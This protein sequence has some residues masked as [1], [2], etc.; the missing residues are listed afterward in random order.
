V[1]VFWDVVD[2]VR[3]NDEFPVLV[4]PRDPE[5][6]EIKDWPLVEMYQLLIALGIGPPLLLALPIDLARQ[7]WWR[8][9]I[10]PRT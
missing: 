8:R 5:H 6:V 10:H 1:K 3:I 9:R 7:I 2:D 4:D